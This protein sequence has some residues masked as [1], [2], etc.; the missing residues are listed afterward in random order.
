MGESFDRVLILRGLAMFFQRSSCFITKSCGE[1]LLSG[2]L[3]W[4]LIIAPE[5]TLGRGIHV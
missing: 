2:S 1:N 3:D 4:V 5:T